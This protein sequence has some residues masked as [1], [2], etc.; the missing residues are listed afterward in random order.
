MGNTPETMA[1]TP[2]RM[3]ENA[4]DRS[5]TTAKKELLNKRIQDAER[6]A[7]QTQLSAFMN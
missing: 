1:T 3:T 5:E 2:P 6:A 7:L 4:K